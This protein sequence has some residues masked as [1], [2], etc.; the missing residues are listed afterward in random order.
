[1]KLASDTIR[2]VDKSFE[3]EQQEEE[4]RGYLGASALGGPCSRQLWYGFRWVDDVTF[5]G[6]VLRLFKRGEREEDVFENLLRRIGCQVWGLDPATKKQYLVK[7]PNP[8]IGG[9]ADGVGVGLMEVPEGV[10]FLV[11]WK[12][13]N[14]SSFNDLVKKGV[15]DSK[16]EHF[17]QCQLYMHGLKLEHALYGAVCKDDDR[18][19]FEM[20]D[21]DDEVAREFITRGELIVNAPVPPYRLSEDPGWYQCKWC[22]F[23][24][25]CHQD[26]PAKVTCR[27]CQYARP[28]GKRT[29]EWICL[30]HDHALSTRAQREAC[31]E[32]VSIDMREV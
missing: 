28:V 13:H 21:Y 20:L 4:P 22:D 2:L 24:K 25:V 31:D 18:L 8:H 10:P 17:V 30:Y 16:R 11:E 15:R 5:P 6:R 32:Y 7:F 29:A 9:H 27:S 23:R 26:K 19:H 12:T 1:M 3:E 14:K